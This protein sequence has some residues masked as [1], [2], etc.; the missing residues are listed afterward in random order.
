M[1]IETTASAH[2]Y[3]NKNKPKLKY[4]SGS[5]NPDE[6]SSGYSSRESLLYPMQPISINSQ[7][8][9]V[10]LTKFNK[11]NNSIPTEEFVSDNKSDKENFNSQPSLTW[12]ISPSRC[13]QHHESISE[14]NDQLLLQNRLLEEHNANLREELQ[15]ARRFYQCTLSELSSQLTRGKT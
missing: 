5:G 6:T 7:K 13:C 3:E 11:S 15:L 9:S 12:G 10:L 4:S 8:E 14:I 2:Q 1:Y